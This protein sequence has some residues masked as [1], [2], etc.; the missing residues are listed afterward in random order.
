MLRTLVASGGRVV[1]TW[2][3]NAANDYARFGQAINTAE[4]RD[5]LF[6]TGKIDRTGKER[7]HRAVPGDPEVATA[8]RRS[9]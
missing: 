8:A 4:F 5:K 9:T 2:P 6:V 7:R 1:D 3:R